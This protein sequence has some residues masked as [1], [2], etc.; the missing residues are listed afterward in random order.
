MVHGTA[1]GT[2][3]QADHGLKGA[4]DELRFSIGYDD[5]LYPGTGAVERT[6][7][8]SPG[9]GHRF[10]VPR[11]QARDR[12]QRVHCERHRY[13]R[14]NHPASEFSN[15]EVLSVW[16]SARDASGSAGAGSLQ[17]GFVDTA[18]KDPDVYDD[19]TTKV[20]TNHKVSDLMSTT[21]RYGIYPRPRSP[22]AT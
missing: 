14:P 1:S 15:G 16:E 13:Q 11:V 2:L 5:S 21:H 3:P 9:R 4:F 18:D 12:R 7:G 17:P 6:L 8:R 20:G 22:T 10:R 19:V